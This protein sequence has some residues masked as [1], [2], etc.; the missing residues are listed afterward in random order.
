MIFFKIKEYYYLFKVVT[1]MN[2]SNK[3]ID[4]NKEINLFNENILTKLSSLF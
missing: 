3:C 2:E 1:V 4:A